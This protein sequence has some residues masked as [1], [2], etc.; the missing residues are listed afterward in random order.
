M[1]FFV[2]SFISV[3]DSIKAQN[4]SSTVE[5]RD[6]RTQAMYWLLDSGFIGLICSCF[7]E[8]VESS[9]SSSDNAIAVFGSSKGETMEQYTGDSEV[10]GRASKEMEFS[11]IH[12]PLKPN[13]FH[14]SLSS[15]PAARKRCSY[16]NTASLGCHCLSSSLELHFQNEEWE[17]L[18]SCLIAASC[19]GDFQAP[20][21]KSVGP[22]RR[23]PLDGNDAPER[24]VCK[25]AARALAILGENEILRRAI[26]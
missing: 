3:C 20:L 10:A 24:R 19:F 17:A 26:R 2:H 25:A 1:L 12:H 9:M 13:F 5:T 14:H 11:L 15:L 8:D 18:L 6:V 22:T 4:R 7:S 16:R 21:K 23:S